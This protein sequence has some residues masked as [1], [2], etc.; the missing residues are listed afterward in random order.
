[1]TS[2]YTSHHDLTN[3]PYQIKTTSR[4]RRVPWIRLSLFSVH[5]EESRFPGSQRCRRLLWNLIDGAREQV[6]IEIEVIST[7]GSTISRSLEVEIMIHRFHTRMM[8]GFTCFFWVWG[9]GVRVRL[10]A[11]GDGARLWDVW[12]GFERGWNKKWNM[13]CWENLWYDMMSI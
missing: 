5:W 1:V 4:T 10:R 8:G 3:A 7:F 12:D 9:L 6:E 11:F 13:I 2:Y